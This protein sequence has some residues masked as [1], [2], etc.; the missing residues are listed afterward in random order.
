MSVLNCHL[1]KSSPRYEK[2]REILG[3]DEPPITNPMPFKTRLG[4]EITWVYAL[5]VAKLTS[6]QR[7]KLVEFIVQTFGVTA[8]KAEEELSTTGFPIRAEDVIVACDHRF[9]T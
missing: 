8:A 6:D 7:A 3:S 5:D 1:I 4:A 2:W 9:F